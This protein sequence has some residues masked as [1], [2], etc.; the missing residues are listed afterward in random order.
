MDNVALIGKGYWGSRLLKYIPKHFDG[1]IVCDSKTNLKEKVWDVPDIQSVIIATPIDTHY[2]LTKQ[3]LQAG[4]NV[5]V[6]KP[7]SLRYDEAKEL[8]ELSREKG[9]KLAVEYT[10]MF[11]RGLDYIKSSDIGEIEFVEMSTKHLG[12]FMDFDVFWLLASHHLSVLPMFF[13][14]SNLTYE[15]KEHMFHNG[16][17]T[18]GSIECYSKIDQM[19][20]ARLD[21][22]LNFH[23]K[24]FCVNVYG[25]KGF[26]RYDPVSDVPV[27]VVTYEKKHSALPKDMIE[28]EDVY[29]VDEMNNLNLSVKY[30]KDLICGKETDN[31]DVA[32]EVTRILEQKS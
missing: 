9:L 10:Q 2:D 13:D 5:L 19:M 6:E 7:L 4:K 15:I 3:A 27:T 17:C 31:L 21:V 29:H 22:S 30:F 23:K 8:V 11:S 25:S 20:K 12:R 32:L 18:T 14:L 1:T 24:E 28:R 16:L 26:A